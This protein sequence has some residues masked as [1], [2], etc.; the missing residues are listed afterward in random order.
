VDGIGGQLAAYAIEVA[1]GG[2]ASARR[3]ALQRR[4]SRCES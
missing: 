1:G 4:R 3:G 2:A